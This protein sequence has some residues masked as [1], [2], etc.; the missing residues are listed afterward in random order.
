MLQSITK[1]VILF[2]KYVS[3]FYTDN[4]VDN[5][6]ITFKLNHS[7]RVLDEAF[8]FFECY[9]YDIESKTKSII[10]AS[11]LFHDVGRFE[12]YRKYKTYSDSLSEDHGDLGAHILK[13]DVFFLD[14]SIDDSIINAVK[15]HNK[16][17]LPESLDML[18]NEVCLFVRD[19]DKIDILK[20]IVNAFE[21]NQINEV[22]S[23]HLK[24][25]KELL[26]ET[27]LNDLI[28]DNKLIDYKHLVYRN[29]MLI[30]MLSW[31]KQFNYKPNLIT[32]IKDN[33]PERLAQ[34]F[35]NKYINTVMNYIENL[36]RSI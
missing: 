30:G 3:N 35:P 15:Y 13:N 22:L 16:K 10:L 25:E 26:S 24:N 33:I 27:L 11:S 14:L 21:L 29:D 34:L 2:K 19:F 32:L 9:K 5:E 12:Q 20:S 4:S 1:N 17:N 28:F 6:N 31:L 18:S 7:L 36:S 23:L 8:N